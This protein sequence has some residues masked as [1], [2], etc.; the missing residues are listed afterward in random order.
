M[1][2]KGLGWVHDWPVIAYSE[3]EYGLGFGIKTVLRKSVIGD[4]MAS[5]IAMRSRS[6]PEK[7]IDV[8]F[9]TGSRP[10]QFDVFAP[11]VVMIARQLH[12]RKPQLRIALQR[13][14][15]IDDERWA[16]FCATQPVDGI[17][18]VTQDSL[19][20]L[21]HSRLMISL[22]GTSTA[23]S[24][25][26]GTP[27]M[28]L[29]PLN[30]LD[31]IQMDGL[32][33]IIGSIPWLGTLLKKL[34][35][36]VMKTKNRKVALPNMIARREIVPE[37]VGVLEPDKIAQRILEV[38]ESPETLAEQRREFDRF[39]ATTAAA[40]RIVAELNQWI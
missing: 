1:Y 16:T 21:A 39:M 14:L 32:L 5:R 12:L 30:R 28:V 29:V 20:T 9:F 27:M 38:L 25:Y 2:A 7:Q 31:L 23:E 18:L 40:D 4:L 26:M 34:A 22:P 36:M 37:L 11:L 35:I 3:H 6:T 33:G 24:M 17:Q 10:K 15:F 13:S 8:V 19:D